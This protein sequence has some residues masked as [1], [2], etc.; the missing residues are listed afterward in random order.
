MA[1]FIN[2][3]PKTTAA[4]RRDLTNQIRAFRSV[5]EFRAALT[6]EMLAYLGCSERSSSHEI[7]LGIIEMCRV[8]NQE[9]YKTIKK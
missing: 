9:L 1:K 4:Q 6:S 5:E 3:T 7:E 8:Y 2:P